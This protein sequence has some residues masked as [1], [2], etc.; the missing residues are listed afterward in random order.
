MITLTIS[1]EMLQNSFNKA[2]EAMMTPGTYENP[3][4]RS[5]DNLIGYSGDKEVKA[6][7]DN[8]VKNFALSYLESPEFKAAIGT[9]MATELA[10]RQLDC[11]K[12]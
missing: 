1:D 8:A 12:K 10:K 5:L 2:L 7:I 6:A 3:V 11:L 4:K 9:A